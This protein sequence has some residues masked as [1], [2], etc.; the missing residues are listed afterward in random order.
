MRI[1]GILTKTP[2]ENSILLIFN[3]FKT[4]RPINLVF[5]AVYYLGAAG[6]KKES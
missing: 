3:T 5:T 1:E 4:A 2:E 6:M